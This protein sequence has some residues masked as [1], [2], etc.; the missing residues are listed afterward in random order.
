MK[1]KIIKRNFILSI[2]A[3]IALMYSCEKE[4]SHNIGVNS[5]YNF[6]VINSDNILKFASEEDYEAAI[7]F[8]NL[9]G[10][11]ELKKFEKNLKFSSLRSK[12]DDDFDQ[13]EIEDETFATLLNFE[14]QIIIGD[15]LFTIDATTDEVFVKQLFNDSSTL[16]S[17]QEF[18]FTFEDDIFSL[19][20]NENELKAAC[21]GRKYYDKT[22]VSVGDIETVLQYHKYGIYFKLKAEVNKNFYGNSVEIYIHL[23]ETV[24]WETRN[25]KKS[26]SYAAG[27]NLGPSASKN[28]EL[29]FYTGTRRL[30]KIYAK[31]VE[32]GWYDYNTDPSP[33]IGSRTYSTTCNW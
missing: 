21:G 27:S 6:K 12:Y 16:K 7:D 31:N 8:L 26:G 1:T 28:L 14:K 3:A 32:C 11:E 10:I 23:H 22:E 30:F 15:Y 5:E 19:L 20:N 17:N 2:L 33:A 24:Y 13:C 9:T 4:N 18:R 29:K 25:G